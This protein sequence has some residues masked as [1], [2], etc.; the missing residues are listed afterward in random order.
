[1]IRAADTIIKL[2]ESKAI[3]FMNGHTHATPEK[4]E[5][6][7]LVFDYLVTRRDLNGAI[8]KW[9]SL[10]KQAD[11]KALTAWHEAV[12]ST[13]E[14][15]RRA[16]PNGFRVAPQEVQETPKVEPVKVEIVGMPQRLTET[17]VHRDASGD[18]A[19]SVQVEKD[20]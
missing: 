1:M 13:L 10:R 3:R 11:A 16:I 12:F 14:Y 6:A 5:A 18:V 9:E 7:K 20:L 17:S 2:A 19:S 4:T 8:L 15:A